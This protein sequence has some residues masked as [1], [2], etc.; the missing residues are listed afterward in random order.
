VQLANLGQA[1]LGNAVTA[2]VTFTDNRCNPCDSR[3]YVSGPG[4]HWTKAARFKPCGFFSPIQNL[5]VSTVTPAC[6]DLRFCASNTRRQQ[7]I[8]ST[9]LAVDAFKKTQ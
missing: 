9:R 1:V 2:A 3:V 7:L 4:H 6:I 5:S 8:K